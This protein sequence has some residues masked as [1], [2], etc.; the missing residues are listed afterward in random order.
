MKII[1]KREAQ[2]KIR[3]SIKANNDLPLIGIEFEEDKT[4]KRLI[5]RESL[6]GAVFIELKSL[7]KGLAF[8][9]SSSKEQTFYEFTSVEDQIEW[10]MFHLNYIPE[11]V[12][13]VKDPDELIAEL[14]KENYTPKYNTESNTTDWISPD[15]SPDFFSTMFHYC[16]EEPITVYRWKENWLKEIER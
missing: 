2:N 6:Y 7:S 10:A 8:L 14:Q 13:V 11:K 12:T 15:S 9:F 16:G 4:I 3:E 1:K 5:L